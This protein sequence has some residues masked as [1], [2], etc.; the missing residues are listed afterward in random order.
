[1]ATRRIGDPFDPNLRHYQV[2]YLSKETRITPQSVMWNC[3]QAEDEDDLLRMAAVEHSTLDVL[4]FRE[5][6]V[7]KCGHGVP[8]LWRKWDAYFR[9]ENK[10]LRIRELRAIKRLAKVMPEARHRS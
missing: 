8:D 7:E 3:E 10:P 4:E 9:N 2:V 6:D 1:M 5:V